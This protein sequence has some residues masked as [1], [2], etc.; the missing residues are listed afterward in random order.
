MDACTNKI[1]FY[2]HDSSLAHLFLFVLLCFKCILLFVYESFAFTGVC[3]SLF[4]LVSTETRRGYQ[5]PGTGVSH[6]CELGIEPG[7]SLR[8]PL[9]S[10]PLS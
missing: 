1:I 9:C 10:T 4:C 7:S 6:Y 3:E 8:P 5:T 2:K